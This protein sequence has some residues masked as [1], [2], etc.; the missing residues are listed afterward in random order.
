MSAALPAWLLEENDEL[1]RTLHCL[2]PAA[3]GD[4]PTASSKASASPPPRR[5][6]AVVTPPVELEPR[7]LNS[8]EAVEP[9]AGTLDAAR[10]A[11]RTQAGVTGLEAK[12][13]AKRIAPP[14]APD[15]LECGVP[16]WLVP[17]LDDGRKLNP[18]AWPL[19]QPTEPPPRPKPTGAVFGRRPGDANPGDEI[20][21]M[22]KLE[23]HLPVERVRP[24][25]TPADA[26][27]PV[28][29]LFPSKSAAP[30]PAA[31]KPPPER[32]AP[33]PK[34]PAAAEKNTLTAI[35]SRR[36]HTYTPNAQRSWEADLAVAP[37]ERGCTA[38]CCNPFV[39]QARP[40]LGFGGLTLKTN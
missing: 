40:Q 11:S 2:V 18:H 10:Y 19:G 23:T 1:A 9:P 20:V 32:P 37:C 30:P 5:A 36:V 38:A 33:P 16:L 35:I 26:L 34:L 15:K 25:A 4:S 12:E 27:P 29:S 14:S 13:W 6:A 17:E 7:R 8:S 31:A 3:P 22:Y 39:E 21:V 24:K 28:E